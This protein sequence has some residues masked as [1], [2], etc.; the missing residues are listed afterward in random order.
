[1]DI[2]Q[3][4]WTYVA[5]GVAVVLFIAWLGVLIQSRPGLIGIVVGFAHL[6]VAGLNSVAPVLAI[7]DPTFGPYGFGLVSAS[8]G[9]Q[10][11]MVA[12]AIFLSAL[13][14][15]FSALRASREAMLMTAC[16]SLLFAIVLGWPW[17]KDLM[18]GIHV[19]FQIGE[20]LTIPGFVAKGL[21][22]I[23]LIAPFLVGFIWALGR[24][25]RSPTKTV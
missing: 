18:D 17:L 12:A 7:L 14:G 21:F 15:A 6:V 23:I 5:G 22:A 19:T 2:S 13:V 4:N 8:S 11:T 3:I 9:L 24:S 1:M 10:I 25:F 20:N 16:T